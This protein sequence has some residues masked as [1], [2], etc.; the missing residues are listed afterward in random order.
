MMWAN[1]SILISPDIL[2]P[3]SDFP[4]GLS[5][6]SQDNFKY[7]TKANQRSCAPCFLTIYN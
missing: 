5:S 7:L 2:V 3:L 1:F 6:K 4:I